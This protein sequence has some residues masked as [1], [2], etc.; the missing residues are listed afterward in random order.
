MN[1]QNLNEQ[2]LG[3]LMGIQTKAPEAVDAMTDRQLWALLGR[4]AATLQ[5]RGRSV[6]ILR[7]PMAQQVLPAPAE[8]ERA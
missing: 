8:G 3:I 5:G 6:A 2:P 4:V 1:V 7:G